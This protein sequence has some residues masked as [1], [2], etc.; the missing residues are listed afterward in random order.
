ME[1]TASGAGMPVHS[2]G[3][4]I[5]MHFRSPALQH[6]PM[7]EQIPTSRAAG[8]RNHTGDE[9][10]SAMWASGTTLPLSVLAIVVR[11]HLRE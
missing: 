11:T 1:L 7:Q 2:P 5:R 6:H 3:S 9:K 4:H 10:N 8:T